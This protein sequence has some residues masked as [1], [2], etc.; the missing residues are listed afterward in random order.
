MTTTTLRRDPQDTAFTPPPRPAPDFRTI[1]LW[2]VLA[3]LLLASIWSVWDLQI[4]LATLIDS[5]GNA[6]D[7]V[8]RI[9]PLDFPTFGEIVASTIETLAIVLL[10]TALSVALSIPVAVFAAGNTT[11]GRGA[12]LSSRVLIVLTRAIP[13]LVLAIVFFRIFGLGALPGVLAMGIHSVGMVGK[14][15]ADAIE[16][17]DPGPVE[18]VRASGGSRLQQVIT[19]V[20]P[21]VMPQF[22]ATALHRFDINLR[23]SV[24]LGYVGVAGIGKEI[25]DSLGTLNYGRGV[26]WALIVLVLCLVTEMVSGAIRAKLLGRRAAAQAGFF[27]VVVRAFDTWRGRDSADRP[28]ARPDEVQRMRSGDVRVAPRWDLDRMSRFGSFVL[29]LVILAASVFVGELH[30]G[31][32]VEKLAALP[33]TLGLFFPPSP[34]G[35][36]ALLLDALV[37]T[38]QIGLAATLL[39][40]VIS[41]PIGV[42]A[43]QNVTGNV[44]VQRFFR[45]LIVTVRSFPDLIIAILFIVV[46][47]LGP[48][49][50]A[51]A[52]AIGSVGL[53]SKLLADSLEETDVRVQE[54]IRAHGATRT[55]VLFSATTRQVMPAFVA[56]LLYQLDVNIRSA[57]LLGIVG[58]GGIGFYLLNASRVMAFDV[59]TFIVLLILGVVLLIEGLSMWTRR[60]VR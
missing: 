32:P 34:G 1:L 49:P 56:H 3:G 24:I 48:V 38:I 6:A 40:A 23:T 14:L 15:Y 58:A 55:Q 54:A 9:L 25:A 47:G 2:V 29:V 12:R 7:F 19:G 51:L 36:L 31:N 33:Q 53:L 44:H 17:I 52:L 21:Q 30:T 13:D 10:A 35:D 5:A 42:L 50:G 16:Q 11:S 18:A 8:S 37:V 45:T 43:A 41:I 27:G 60:A 20:F 39:G 28:A 59:V 46:T 26:A 4:N 22:V 57:T